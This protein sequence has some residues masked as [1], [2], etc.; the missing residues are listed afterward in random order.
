MT[1]TIVDSGPLVAYF[2]ARDRWHRW[3]VDQ[4]TTLYPALVTC[5][6]VLTE[7]GFLIHRAGGHAADLIRKLDQGVLKV[8]IDGEEEAPSVEALLGRYEDTPMS[9]AEACLVRL[10]ERYS[11]SRLFTLDS[12]FGH[13]R[14][15]GRHVIPLITPG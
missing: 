1:R 4:T 14:R 3:V 13:Y 5:E 15:N 7:A 9:L 6:P 8:A 11:D 12:D 10:T 2:N